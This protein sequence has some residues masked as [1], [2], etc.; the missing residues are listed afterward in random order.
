MELKSYQQKVIENLEEYLDYI[1]EQKNL[2]KAF[3]QYWEDKIG[4]YN[5]FDNTGMQPLKIPFQMLHTFV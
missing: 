1:Q 2:P 5:P 3:N 4:P